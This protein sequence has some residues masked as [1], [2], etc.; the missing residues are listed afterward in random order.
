MVDEIF[1]TRELEL[2]E[3]L[4]EAQVNYLVVG[5]AAVAI[6]GYRRP[7][8]DLDLLLRAT[9][10]NII[11]LSDV[12]L[13]WIR[14]GS[15]TIDKLKTGARYSSPERCID[16]MFELKGIL[17]ADAFSNSTVHNE[18][19]LSVPVISKSDLIA[20]KE[21]IGEKI[22]LEDIAALSTP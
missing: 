19:G 12:Q 1:S 22:D 9:D 5:G 13:S 15:S 17:A 6:H 8:K 2:L 16:L 21:A 11:R 4:N 18:A 10:D 7:R 14:F 3:S 20:A